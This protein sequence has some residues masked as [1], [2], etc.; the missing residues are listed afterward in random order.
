MQT[1]QCGWVVLLY[2]ELARTLY[3]RC[4]YG[5]FGREIT[6]F[7]V[8]YGAYIHGSGTPLTKVI[9]HRTRSR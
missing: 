8:M 9:R 2:V 6:K 3:I 1:Q 7:T 5:V 4:I